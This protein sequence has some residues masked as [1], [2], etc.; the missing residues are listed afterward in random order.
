M[1]GSIWLKQRA[2]TM[3]TARMECVHWLPVV[4]PRCEMRNALCS[5]CG[6]LNVRTLAQSIVIDSI[7]GVEPKAMADRGLIE[8]IK[9]RA[10]V[11]HNEALIGQ[12]GFR[13]LR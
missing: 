12:L 6:K 2:C 7:F 9:E 4:S 13:R 11:V 3:T 5:H 1:Q 10:R 8:V